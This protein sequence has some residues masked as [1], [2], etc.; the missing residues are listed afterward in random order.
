MDNTQPSDQPS[1]AT[2]QHRTH[3][4]TDAHHDSPEG[5][6]GQ[7]VEQKARERDKGRETHMPRIS[8]YEAHLATPSQQSQTPRPTHRP[9]HPS[10]QP[11]CTTLHPCAP[12]PPV[13]LQQ[14]GQKAGKHADK[15]ATGTQGNGRTHAEH[16]T[17]GK[18]KPAT[19]RPRRRH[20][21]AAAFRPRWRGSSSLAAAPGR[22]SSLPAA[23]WRPGS[24][25]AAAPG[26]SSSLPAALWRPGRSLAAAP[27]RGETGGSLTAAPHTRRRAHSGA[28]QGSTAPG[29]PSTK[30]PPTQR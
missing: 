8:R 11:R 27:G 7:Y 20:G 18:R 15:Q 2:G 29:W 4:Q 5:Q 28:G 16:R 6:Q 1:E 14:A 24:S 19:P 23:L 25:L 30:L 17:K 21:K 26:R 9:R 13:G 3:G 22:S 10:S 12:R